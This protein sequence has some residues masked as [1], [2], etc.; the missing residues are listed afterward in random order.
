MLLLSMATL[1]FA[2]SNSPLE[3]SPISTGVLMSRAVRAGRV[4][5]SGSAFDNGIQPSLTCIPVPCVF[6]NVNVSQSPVLAHGLPV[7]VHPQNSQQIL[8]VANYYNCAT[9][10][11]V[12]YSGDGS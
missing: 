6:P 8:S 10:Q 9:I 1:T 12:Y 7:L 3:K 11:D 2:Q 4:H 5:L